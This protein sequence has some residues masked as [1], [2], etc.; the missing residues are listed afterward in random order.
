MEFGSYPDCFVITGGTRD[1]HND[2]LWCVWWLRGG[3]D[4]CLSIQ[5][6]R[7]RRDGCLSIQMMRGGRDGCLSIQMMRGGRDGC[8]SIQ[9]LR[10]GRDGCLSIQMMRGGRDGCL[11]IQMM[12]GG[13]D[14]C[15]PIQ[16]LSNQYKLRWCIFLSIYDMHRNTH[17]SPRV[18]TVM[19]SASLLALGVVA[20]CGGL[21]GIVAGFDFKCMF[22]NSIQVYGNLLFLVS[23]FCSPCLRRGHV[24]QI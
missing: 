19:T 4:G 1:C 13:R 20:G 22:R 23:L 17:S 24:C 12:R 9:M 2:N 18:V 5:M 14:G 16:M 15:L 21:V 10:G 3:R 11:S 6:L 8:L 7:G